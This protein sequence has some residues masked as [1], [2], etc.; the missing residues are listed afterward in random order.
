MSVA[1]ERTT[2]EHSGSDAAIAHADSE[3]M[4]DGRALVEPQLR[5]GDV[6]S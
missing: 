6:I 3:S 5:S 4:N 1:E 2:R